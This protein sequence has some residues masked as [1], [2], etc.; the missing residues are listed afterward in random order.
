MPSAAGALLYRITAL[1]FGSVDTTQVAVQAYYR[2]AL[3]SA[4]PP[5]PAPP[6]TTPGGAPGQGPGHGPGTGPN[7]APDAG[8][9]ALPGTPGGPGIRVGW[10]E[11]GN[12]HDSV[13]AAGPSG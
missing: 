13:A 5:A 7:D 12:W 8:T 1:G 6:G 11:I 2:K 3:A 9:P 4:G 10:R